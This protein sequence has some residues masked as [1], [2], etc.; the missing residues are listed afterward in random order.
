VPLRFTG[1]GLPL[2]A[3]PGGAAAARSAELRGP[4]R[5]QVETLQ[6]A[7]DVMEQVLGSSLAP[8]AFGMALLMIGNRA[9]QGRGTALATPG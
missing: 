2:Q 3:R 8:A 4:R 9:V 6:Q 1:S 5:P 7:H